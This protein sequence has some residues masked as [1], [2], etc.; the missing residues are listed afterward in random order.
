MPNERRSALDRVIAESGVSDLVDVLS[1]RLSGSDLT[2]L[3]LEV[4]RRRATDVPPP[5]LLQ[6]YERDRFVRPA[7]LP[8]TAFYAAFGHAVK[9]LPTGV[10]MVE[11]APVVPLGTHAALGTVSQNKVVSTIRGTEVAA[12]VTNALALEAAVRRKA[13]LA[14]AARSAVPV[15]LGAAQ[16][17]V[18]AQRFDGPV[19]FAHFTLFGLVTAGRDTGNRQF[20][21]D[22]FREHCRFHVE[23]VL[24][25]GAEAVEVRLSA[26]DR[27]FMAV[28]DA[29]REALGDLRGATVVDD[30]DRRSGRN[31]YTGFCFKVYVQ[32]GDVWIDLADG[33]LVDWTQ[34]L[35]Q[36]RKERLVISGL[37]MERLAVLSTPGG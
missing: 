12:D 31:Y 26:L 28:A 22:A 33:G 30:P 35:L 13:L 1:A 2:T 27:G 21:I 5:S 37:G 15:R 7:L 11:L 23:A 18:R 29:V 14:A 24:A 32:D 19:Q 4:M 16:R 3:L 8:P 25:A 34:K 9:A 36:N 6:Q 10:E 20:E 17:V